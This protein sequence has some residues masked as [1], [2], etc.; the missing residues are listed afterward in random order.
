M[1]VATAKVALL[2]EEKAAQLRWQYGLN[3]F[4]LYIQEVLGHA[5]ISYTM[6]EDADD[7]RLSEADVVVAGLTADTQESAEALWRYAELGGTVVAYG[8]LN[9]LAAR[10][11]CVRSQATGT[12]YAALD[13]RAEPIRYLQAEVW[14]PKEPTPAVTA[15][16]TLRNGTPDGPAIGPALLSFQVGKGSVHRWAVDIPSTIVALQ[17]GAAP[18]LQDGVPA[19]DGTGALDE[20][21]L[22]AD[23]VCEMDWELDRRT[24]DTG[25]VYYAF[26]YA[27]YWRE[28]LLGHLLGAAAERGLAIPFLDVWPDGVEQVALISLDSDMNEDAAAETTL[29]V[30]KACGVPSTWCMIE[31]GFGEAV[32]KRAVREGHELAFHYNAL[33]QEKGVWGAQEFKRQLEWARR[34]TGR[35]G[36]VSNKNHYTR[37]EGWGELFRWL[38]AADIQADQTRG[39]SK[40]G[41]IGFLFGTCHP[42][43]PIAWSDEENRMYDV[44]EVG[45]LTQDL[46]HPMLAD[47]SVAVPFLDTVRGVRGL[48]HFLFHQTHIHHKEPVRQAVAKVVAEAERRGFA[49]WTCEQINE[50][51]RSRRSVR[52]RGAGADG[53]IEAEAGTLAQDAVVWVPRTAAFGS[54]EPTELR[55]GVPCVKRV[56]RAKREHKEE[57]V[58]NG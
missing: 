21:I 4:Q 42:Y 53:A 49:F 35:Q 31:P 40:K 41:N 27:D 5:G 36:I 23:D 8:G 33:E 11:D 44:L 38:E 2:F 52:I 26:P 19:K 16:G 57:A 43:F 47:D 9:K 15:K 37:F 14:T 17:Q 55:Y 6:L 51:E 28:A 12:G 58:A 24:T 25:A 30:L 13:G 34:A 1:T 48:A 20:Y 10:L 39:P 22:K 54:G 56:L 29:D 18:V 7:A 32:Y 3:V 46:N 45:F 50:W